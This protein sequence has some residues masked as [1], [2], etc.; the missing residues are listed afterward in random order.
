MWNRFAEPARKS[1]LYAQEEAGRLKDRY[2][3]TEHLLLGNLRERDKGA[4]RVLFSMGVDP[5]MIDAAVRQT[6]V[7]GD[8]VT[9]ADM[10]LTPRV[11][12]SIDFSYD[13]T[14]ALNATMLDTEHLLLG[15]MRVTDGLAFLVL[16]EQ[17]ITLDGARQIVANG[18]D[19][20][21]VK[22]W[23]PAV[24]GAE[25]PPTPTFSYN[26]I[27]GARKDARLNLGLASVFVGITLA[28]MAQD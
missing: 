16:N 25:Q 9:R 19:I 14:Q 8:H 6:V 22:G 7:T 18:V 4:C 26:A 17:G 24:T 12:L 23:P 28:L 2:V 11:K 1:V 10:A 13:E 3:S 21:A 15:L 5:A 20:G 27:W